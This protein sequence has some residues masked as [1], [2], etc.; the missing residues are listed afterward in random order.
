[1]HQGS[2]H[3]AGR[4]LFICGRFL[5]FPKSIFEKK[6]SSK[7]ALN[8]LWSEAFTGHPALG[9]QGHETSLKT[10]PPMFCELATGTENKGQ[11][12]LTLKVLKGL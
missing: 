12:V 6:A 1:M 8:F 10:D 7:L 5:K 2:H 4:R 3:F 9:I 11:R